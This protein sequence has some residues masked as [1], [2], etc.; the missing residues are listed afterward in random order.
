MGLEIENHL[1]KKVC[2]LEKKKIASDQMF[3]NSLT[4]LRHHHSFHRMQIVNILE[5]EKSHIKSMFSMIEG[6]IKQINGCKETDSEHSSDAT[7]LDENYYTDRESTE[8]ELS[9]APEISV[10]GIRL[11]SD[12]DLADSKCDESKALAQALQEKVAALLLL[13]QQEER[14]L[15]E[16]NVNAALQKKVEELQWNL[17]QVTN[18]KVKAL[19]E[20]AQLKQNYHLLKERV[21]PEMKISAEDN[22]LATHEHEGKLRNILKKSYLSRWINKVDFGRNTSETGHTNEGN[23]S[24][25]HS[26]SMEIA[27]MKIENATLRESLESMEHITSTIHRLR[28][29]LSQVKESAVLGGTVTGISQVLEDTISEAMLMRTALSSCLPVSW[30]AGED[31]ESLG[32]SVDD[33]SSDIHSDSINKKLDSVSAAGFEMV[34]LLILTA[35]LL[36]EYANKIKS[37]D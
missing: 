7:K 2:E 15:L 20:L 27:R 19:M 8:A 10:A 5:E 3:R 24:S 36:K 23:F 35:D 18:E 14:H 12:L 30:S 6:K 34:E 28:A 13:S 22:R 16:R 25:R 29:S 9:M 26:N 1:K 4:G 31:M 37:E 11:K 21:G 33:E 32:G 17:L